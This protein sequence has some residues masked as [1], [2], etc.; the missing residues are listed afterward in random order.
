MRWDPLQHMHLVYRAGGG[1]G[2]QSSNTTVNQLYSPEEAARRAALMAEAERVYRTTSGTVPN[3]PAP[4]AESQQAQQMMMQSAQGPLQQIAGMMPGAMQFGMSDVLNPASNPALQQTLDTATRRV[5]QA[6]TDPGGVISRIKT[7]FDTNNSGGTSTRE[8]IAGGIA[9]RE[10]LNTVGDVTGNIMNNAYTQ[11]L[12]T[13]SRT[14]ALAPQAMQ[15]VTAPASAVSSVGAQ[16]EGYEDAA[17]QWNL[18][19]PWANLGPYAQIVHGLSNPST[20]T[21]T[22]AP[23][24]SRNPM[25]PLGGAMAGA[26]VGSMIPGVGTMVGAGVGLALSLF[27]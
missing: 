12:N 13:F 10:Y 15:A 8:G 20:S 6:Y 4:S 18:S 24:P 14:M 3:A 21:S 7:N 22:T 11:G 25:G 27:K 19:A 26:A 2:Q 1:G 5:G 16:K 17:R 9:G 23:G